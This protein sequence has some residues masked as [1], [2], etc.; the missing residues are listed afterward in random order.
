MAGILD[1]TDIMRIGVED[2]GYWVVLE[3]MPDTLK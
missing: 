3:N 1:E 2:D